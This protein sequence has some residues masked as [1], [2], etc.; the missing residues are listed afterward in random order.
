NNCINQSNMLRQPTFWE[1]EFKQPLLKMDRGFI[2]E[3]GVDK[4][5]ERMANWRKQLNI[6]D[7]ELKPIDYGTEEPQRIF[8][9]DAERTFENDESK[10][11]L[12]RILTYLNKQFG[13]YQQGMS[14][15]TSFLMLGM[16]EHQAIAVLIKINALLPGYWKHEAINF[17]T[18]AFTF[19]HLLGDFHP[20]IKAHLA[21]NLIDP[22]TFCQRWFLGL[23]VHCLPFRQLFRFYDQFFEGGRDY[24]LRFGL[25]LFGAL[26]DLVL[27]TTN[28]NMIFGLL[29]LDTGVATTLTEKHF[30]E[31]LDTTANYDI[32]KYD[33]E[34]I[35]KE[36]YDL[37]LKKRIESAHKV[38]DAVEE[39]SDCQW[40]MDNLPELYC[41]E[42]GKVVCQDCV[43][44]GKGENHTEDHNLISLEEYEDQLA[45]AKKDR[46]QE[47]LTTKL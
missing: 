29:R 44:D 35:R 7:E 13:D 38:H 33:L 40:C 20:K 27:A 15:V 6:I 23:C 1:D 11:R 4:I 46:E 19:Y 25:A 3:E 37:K 34:A 24:L 8:V 26:S 28:P 22:A 17:G 5:I 36:Q 16:E 47:A 9:L 2:K 41:V 14:F 21:A 45:Q 43:D 10:K 42:C 31:I 30:D 39:I 18:E 12:V 32:S